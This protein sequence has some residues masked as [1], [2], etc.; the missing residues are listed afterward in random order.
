MENFPPTKKDHL[1]DQ[2]RRERVLTNWYWYVL[3]KLTFIIWWRLLWRGR[4]WRVWHQCLQFLL[5]VS[6]TWLVLRHFGLEFCS[7]NKKRFGLYL[8]SKTANFADGVWPPELALD[9]R[10]ILKFGA[11]KRV[12]VSYKAPTLG[13]QGHFKR[14]VNFDASTGG[15]VLIRVRKLWC[16]F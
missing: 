1:F 2:T 6:L 13:L 16:V 5:G 8:F 10:G 14:V 3:Y 9:F 11:A 15:F 4:G 12:V 7:Q